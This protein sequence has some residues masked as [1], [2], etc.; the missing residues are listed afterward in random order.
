MTQSDRIEIPLSKAKLVLLLLGAIA[1][2]AIGLYLVI[3][4]PVSPIFSSHLFNT[5]VGVV[6]ILFAGLG[7]IF[8]LLKLTD[9]NPG[10]VLDK[11]GITVNAGPK[12]YGLIRWED[13]SDIKTEL[14]YNQKMLLVIVKNP[15]YY[16]VMQNN[17]L[18]K[19]MLK[20]NLKYLATPITIS[21]NGLKCNF[22]Q[23]S[24][25]VQAK[26]KEYCPNQDIKH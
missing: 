20:M 6:G 14:I 3:S 26:F 12:S 23:L 18:V 25:I 11:E 9:R 24:N 4:Q 19:F 1:F 5:D 8:L 10:I 17:N 7:F 16:I 13:I 22:E 2:V 21:A 15:E